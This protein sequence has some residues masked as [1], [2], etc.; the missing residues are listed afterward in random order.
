MRTI[1]DILGATPDGYVECEYAILPPKTVE[2]LRKAFPEMEEK[3]S[4][5]IWRKIPVLYIKNLI[6]Q[7]QA[8]KFYTDEIK[9]ELIDAIKE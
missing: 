9:I 7:L 4:S 2:A 5:K 6:E 3:Y 1:T 8:T